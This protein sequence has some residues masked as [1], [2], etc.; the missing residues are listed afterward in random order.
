MDSMETRFNFNPD[1]HSDTDMLGFDQYIQTLGGMIK[2][3]NFKTPF[4]IGVYGTWGSGKTT[5]M[6]LLSQ[7]ICKDSGKP[8]VI[9]VWFNPWRYEKE[10]HLI[11]PFL[12]TIEQ[13]IKAYEE[14]RKGLLG[15]LGDRLQKV[16]TRIATVAAALAYSTRIDLDVLKI[17]FDKAVKR[18]EELLERKHRKDMTLG[19]SLSSIYYDIISQLGEFTD[20]K[21]FRIAVFIDDL[22][23]CLPEKAIELLEAMKLFLD[24]TGYL[25][26]IGVDRSVVEKGIACHYRLLMPTSRG[27]KVRLPSNR[28]ITLI[29]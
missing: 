28:M 24:L 8:Y 11:I 18:E 16:A 17:D 12:K 15:S 26:I 2:D 27:P 6:R 3:P 25:F 5:F 9:P 20:E 1:V 13:E 29:K 14:K 19:N 22:D 23:R 7:E 21:T 4:C 10:E